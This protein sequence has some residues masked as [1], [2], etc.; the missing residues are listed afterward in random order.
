MGIFLMFFLSLVLADQVCIRTK[1]KNRKF[2]YRVSKMPYSGTD[3]ALKMTAYLNNGQKRF[4]YINKDAKSSGNAASGWVAIQ[5]V[6]EHTDSCFELHVGFG[7]IDLSKNIKIEFVDKSCD[8]AMWVDRFFV[9]GRAS[10]GIMNQAGWCM[11]SKKYVK[12]NK[13]QEVMPWISWNWGLYYDGCLHT[14]WLKSDGNVAGLF[15]SDKKTGK[16]GSGRRQLTLLE[17]TAEEA[18]VDPELVEIKLIE[19]LY[20]ICEQ[21]EKRLSV[22]TR[23][24]SEVEEIVQ[25][26]FKM[27]ESFDETYNA[28]RQKQLDDIPPQYRHENSRMEEVDSDFDEATTQNEKQ[29][30]ASRSEKLSLEEINKSLRKVLNAVGAN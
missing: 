14:V 27:L 17:P 16:F 1:K 15:G 13:K 24:D 19:N 26:C 20:D 3:C 2:P 21:H 23:F 18:K 22:Q 12:H 8:D 4:A 9:P 25:R 10:W 5:R 7:Q 30:S 28:Y 6:H 11:N 29:Q